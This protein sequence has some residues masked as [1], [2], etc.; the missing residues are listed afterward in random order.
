FGQDFKN[1]VNKSI[2]IASK[3]SGDN[4][5]LFKMRGDRALAPLLEFGKFDEDFMLP[6]ADGIY[7]NRDNGN[8]DG[9]QKADLLNPAHSQNTS[10]LNSVLIGLGRNPQTSTAFFGSEPERLDRV[11]ELLDRAKSDDL[12][13]SANYL[14]QALESGATGR[15]AGDLSAPAVRHSTEMASIA[16]EVVKYVGNHPQD[17]DK[18]GT[19]L[20]PMIDSAANIGVEYMEDI[21]NAFAVKGTES[22]DPLPYNGGRPG[23]LDPEWLVDTFG[24]PA[25]L[26]GEDGDGL[27]GKE[28]RTFL[29]ALG[30]DPA[31]NHK[32]NV[33]SAH[34]ANAGLSQVTNEDHQGAM[35]SAFD[36]HAKVAGLLDRGK[37]DSIEE[38]AWEDDLTKNAWNKLAKETAVY[39]VGK[40]PFFGAEAAATDTTEALKGD[41]GFG[42]QPG[43]N[44]I[45]TTV[46]AVMDA[47][48]LGEQDSHGDSQDQRA[49]TAADRTD[50]FEDEVKALIDAERAARGNEPSPDYKAGNAADDA[51]AAKKLASVY[52]QALRGKDGDLFKPILARYQPDEPY[53]PTSPDG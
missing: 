27:G 34:V 35:T 46:E 40:I 45:K 52:E 23:D 36:S 30:H 17:I 32:L 11:A 51:Y 22:D 3:K 48:N 24:Q 29:E 25:S 42:V 7:E 20:R 2:W 13:L 9:V 12:T 44:Y 53:D 19:D 37:L 15:P 4:H 10:P 39:G 49:E 31:S 50:R 21:H 16:A 5:D 28:T 33:A 6:V 26:F 1:L 18:P 38:K 8:P 47:V 41:V 43:S 14:G